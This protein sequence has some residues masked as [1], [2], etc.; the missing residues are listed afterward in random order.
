MCEDVC[1]VTNENYRDLNNFFIYWF[2]NLIQCGRIPY[3][4]GLSVPLVLWLYFYHAKNVPCTTNLLSK[5]SCYLRNYLWNFQQAVSGE[6]FKRNLSGVNI[7]RT[8]F[9][10]IN[11]S[12]QMENTLNMRKIFQ[13]V[14]I[15]ILKEQGYLSKP[16]NGRMF[17]IRVT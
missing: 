13:W 2:S 12:F 5:G 1:L 15:K 9:Y 3:T 16:C 7:L 10:P 4:Q 17:I 6:N 11:W 14:K 8:H